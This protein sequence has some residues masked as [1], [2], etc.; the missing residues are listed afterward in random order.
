MVTTALAFASMWTLG[1]VLMERLDAP[2]SAAV[3]GVWAGGLLGLGLG[4]GQ[5]VALRGT[6]VNS[7]RW[8]IYS[9]LGGAVGFAL[10][11]VLTATGDTPPALL[12]VLAGSALGLGIGVAQWLLLRARTPKPLIWIPTTLVAFVSAMVLAY[13][14]VAGREWLILIAMGLVMAVITGL[15]AAWLFGGRRPAIAGQTGVLLVL[16]LLLAGCS[17]VNEPVVRFVEPRAGASVASP[18][19]VVMSA[20]DFTV[21]PAGDGAIHD[22]AG[23]LHIMV[24]TPCV[25]AGNTIPKDETHLHFGDGSTETQ[26]EL[27]PGEHT[28]CLQAA[29]GAHTALP[30]EGM[31]HTISVTVP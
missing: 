18:V 30:G 10:F 19:R 27:A 26:L 13:G 7:A 23:H 8:V 31:T 3:S 6:G 15:A 22:G 9:A 1:G 28:L 17:G 25:E 5:A 2:F 29:D 20:E 21:E 14:G 12:A 4:L 11:S 24:D 16:G